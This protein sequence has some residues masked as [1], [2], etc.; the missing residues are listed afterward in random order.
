MKIF[1]KWLNN[2][3]NYCTMKLI[4]A[5]IPL[6]LITLIGCN[7]QVSTSEETPIECE[8]CPTCDSITKDDKYYYETD[9]ITTEKF[10]KFF[11][12]TLTTSEIHQSSKFNEWHDSHLVN[13]L[14][15]S[16]RVVIDNVSGKLT[17]VKL[18]FNEIKYLDP[19]ETK[20]CEDEIQ[21]FANKQT[22]YNTICQYIYGQDITYK[23]EDFTFSVLEPIKV[24]FHYE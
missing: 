11:K 19:I 10:A 7:K 6:T 16:Q 14:V 8:K 2:L 12:I 3:Y 17:K 5:L 20:Y 13:K 1:Y 24:I 18:S 4:K 15:I 9:E 22:T 21:L 23:L